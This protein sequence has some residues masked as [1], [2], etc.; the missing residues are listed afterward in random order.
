MFSCL[1]NFSE[2]I[3]AASIQFSTP[4]IISVTVRFSTQPTEMNIVIKV[5]PPL[6]ITN[7]KF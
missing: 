4:E 6:S 5:F 1:K 7:R 2:D 3:P